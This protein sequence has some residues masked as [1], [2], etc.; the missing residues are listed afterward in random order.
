MLK[1]SLF[2]KHDFAAYIH[3]VCYD[4]QNLC[5][6]HW[7]Q[8]SNY[9]INSHS[10]IKEYVSEESSRFHFYGGGKALIFSS[11]ELCTYVSADL[12][13]QQYQ[14][15]QCVKKDNKQ[16]LHLNDGDALCSVPLNI[17][18]PKLTLKAAKEL[19]NLHNM[20]MPSK[21]LLKNAQILLENHKC[22][23]CPDLLAVFKPYRVASNTERQKTWYQKNTEKRTSY[24]KH[25]YP[26]SEYQESQKK[27]SQKYYWFKKDVKFPPVPPSSELCQKI[28]SEFCAD[29]SPDV[30]KEAGCAVC[31]KLTP[32]CEMEEL[33][34]VE[35]VN[36][37]KFDGVTRKARCKSTDPVREFRGP[38]LA[39][40]CSRVCPICVESLD[41]KKMPTLALANGLW[42][43]EIPDELQNLT[44][45]HWKGS[46]Q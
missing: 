26:T 11:D 41:K 34:E 44:V 20:Y 19:A 21:I 10:H 27:S 16:N 6:W 2:R 18:A 38:I 7:K 23:T 33:S 4:Y 24:E 40:G 43:G 32:I 22:E 39:P 36:L 5:G 17:L 13:E 25:R 42:V 30:F 37:L 29:T 46:S 31:G 8:I 1:K 15:Q 28:I 45:A 35:N 9:K 14:F 12:H 3:R